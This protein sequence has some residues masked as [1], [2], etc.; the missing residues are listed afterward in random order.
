ML[1]SIVAIIPARGG[2]KGIPRKNVRLLDGRPLIGHAIVAARQATSVGRVIVT[3]DDAEIASVATAFGADVV[4]RPAELS[5][6]TASS[7][8]ALLHALD[9]I[10][11]EGTAL[12]DAIAFLQCTSPFLSA[13]DIDATVAAMRDDD[14]DCAFTA[15]RFHHFVWA[16]D[17]LGRMRG[18]NHDPAV[19]P[20]RQQREAQYLETGAVYVMKTAGFRAARHRFFGKVAV[21]EVPPERALEIDSPADFELAEQMMSA[22]RGADAASRLPATIGAVVFD[23]DGVMTDNRVFIL[24]DGREAVA[25][26]RGDGMGISALRAKGIPMLVLSKERNPV[27]TARCAK[28]QVP[29]LQG[30]DDKPEALRH[31]LAGQE[32]ALADVVYVGN[33][34]NDLDCLRI[35]GCG[36]IVGDAHRGVHAAAQ[37]RLEAEGGRGAVR[38]LTD[39]IIQKLE[40]AS[41]A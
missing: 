13:A 35:A 24:E 31:W 12:P 30:V 4:A 33:D 9:T 7:E 27:V 26:N 40:S 11:A 3:T 10:E 37:I 5:G 23:F 18:V 14:A 1:P 15:T 20:M 41:L 2:S 25:C 28:L 29:C 19:R 36:V 8:A 17:P 22:A 34:V 21:C 38:E 16:R 32:I 39:L 6:D